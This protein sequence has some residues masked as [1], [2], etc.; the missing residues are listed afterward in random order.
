[1]LAT[2]P[3]R[4]LAGILLASALPLLL[5]SLAHAGAGTPPAVVAQSPLANATAVP[6]GAVVT[7]TFDEAIDAAA[8][9][10]TSLVFSCD[11]IELPGTLAAEGTQLRFTPAA[12]LPSARTCSV[13]IPAGA[14]R[15]LGGVPTATAFTWDFRTVKI[16]R[17]L[18]LVKQGA[19]SGQVVGAGNLP[20]L[21][22]QYSIDCGE[23]CNAKVLA[24]NRYMLRAMPTGA[25]KFTGWVGCP[26]PDGNTCVIPEMTR[27]RTVSAKFAVADSGGLAAIGNQNIMKVA[28]GGHTW[29]LADSSVYRFSGAGHRDLYFNNIPPYD[30]TPIAGNPNHY[31][32]NGRVSVAVQ[33]PGTQMCSGMESG[34]TMTLDTSGLAPLGGRYVASECEIDVQYVSPR[35][36]VAGVVRQATLVNA[37]GREIEVVNVPFRVYRHVGPGSEDSALRDDA[38]ISMYIDGG[39]AELPALRQ[40]QMTRQVSNIGSAWG[41][42]VNTPDG[43]TQY[44]G[45]A[46][47]NIVFNVQNASDFFPGART[48]QCG[49]RLTANSPVN[50]QLFL[51]SYLA[52]YVFASG[53]SGGSC[54][55]DITQKSG[56]YFAGTYTATLIGDAAGSSLLTAEQR[57]LRVHGALR[58]FRLDAHKPRKGDRAT[59]A[60][61]QGS[62]LVTDG[63]VA[64]TAADRY[65]LKQPGAFQGQNDRLAITLQWGNEVDERFNAFN[66]RRD[67]GFSVALDDIPREVGTYTCGSSHVVGATLWPRLRVSSD[68]VGLLSSV[69][70]QSGA[71]VTLPG[72]SCTIEI[73]RY[74]SGA[75]K[76]RYTA[77]LV[78]DELAGVVPGGD[79]T[80]TIEGEF[81]LAPQ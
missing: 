27:D 59:V 58:N 53:F 71:Y 52:E 24:G 15:D 38:Y 32:I 34:V 2:R 66:K 78:N 63:N 21:S 39:T 26:Q 12:P 17:D 64:F 4:P 45:N 43:T 50:I 22:G 57:T 14:V 23:R 67:D 54:T 36:S 75:I 76:G 70:F 72:A 16:T 60:E 8:I 48:Y 55:F 44:D 11:N 9:N 31:L 30:L 56:R 74:D 40:F 80:M 73:S 19:G 20:P 61:G 79:A 41:A 51:G 33:A 42:G 13:F 7:A 68:R 28:I 10:S 18:T 6:R 29:R 77:T 46:S 69:R 5:S 37:S 35:G 62:L 3:R 65:L 81:H 25:S 49:E 1:M 47:D